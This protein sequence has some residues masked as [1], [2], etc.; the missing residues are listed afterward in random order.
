MTLPAFSSAPHAIPFK[1]EGVEESC[2]LESPHPPHSLGTRRQR[3]YYY[4]SENTYVEID[5]FVYCLG[6]EGPIEVNGKRYYLRIIAER[7]TPEN[8]WI[9]DAHIGFYYLIP[10]DEVTEALLKMEREAED[11]AR[12]G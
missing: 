6:K 10:L 7:T 9:R 4:Y 11:R 1:Y 8:E 2:G 12:Q 5:V 3:Y